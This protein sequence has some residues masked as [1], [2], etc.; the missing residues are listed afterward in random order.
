[1][2]HLKVVYIDGM[3][4]IDG[5][6]LSYSY[7]KGMY[8][9]GRPGVGLQINPDVNEE[10]AHILCEKIAEALVEYHEPTVADK[11]AQRLSGLAMPVVSF[12][13]GYHIHCPYCQRKADRKLSDLSDSVFE[14][15]YTCEYCEK[16]FRL[17]KPWESKA[18]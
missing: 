18:E 14:K 13:S 4:N 12:P 1:M 17:R 2:N 3:V 9:G 16:T 6:G 11:T 15:D 10:K 7:V 5:E 8:S